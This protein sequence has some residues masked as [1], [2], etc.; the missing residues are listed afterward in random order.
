MSKHSKHFYDTKTPLVID[1]LLKICRRAA[2]QSTA[3]HPV[4]L[5]YAM[6]NVLDAAELIYGSMDECK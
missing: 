6:Q 3:A 5:I 1:Q 2:E 4:D